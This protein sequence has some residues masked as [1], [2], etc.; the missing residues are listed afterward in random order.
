MAPLD[1][2]P[3]PTTLGEIQPPTKPETPRKPRGRPLKPTHKTPVDIAEFDAVAA[4]IRSIPNDHR[5]AASERARQLAG[6]D[7]RL[8]RA[9]LVLLNRLIDADWATGIF[10]KSLTKLADE[11]GLHRSTIT[12]AFKTLAE[13]GCSLRRQK[14]RKDTED[15]ERDWDQSEITLPIVAR[16]WAELREGLGAE[17]SEGRRAK[18]EGRCERAPTLGAEKSEVGPDA[19]LGWAQENGEARREKIEGRREKFTPPLPAWSDPKLLGWV[20]DDETGQAAFKTEEVEQL[21]ATLA[22]GLTNEFLGDLVAKS[23]PELDAT[24]RTDAGLDAFRTLIAGVIVA[25][26]PSDG[27]EV[28]VD[29]EMLLSAMKRVFD[30]V[31]HCGSGADGPVKSYKQ[32]GTILAFENVTWRFAIKVPPPLDTGA[33]SPE[34]DDERQML[35]DLANTVMSSNVPAEKKV[36]QIRAA[37]K[38]A[39]C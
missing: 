15:R 13:T 26:N 4:S 39:A 2:S 16:V 28:I 5:S 6:Q 33:G 24:L 32:P 21:T 17:K 11:C 38:A 35:L 14:R 3:A 37:I 7:A 30:V 1:A 34:L 23:L 31:F 9:P 10:T 8:S 29:D 12:R 18:I 25:R 19:G 36:A 27:G 22:R 20:N